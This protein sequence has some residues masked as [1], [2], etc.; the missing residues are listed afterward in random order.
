MTN[1][2][3]TRELG[4]KWA[5]SGTVARARN[6][7]AEPTPVISDA[8][9]QSR[10]ESEVGKNTLRAAFSMDLDEPGLDQKAMARGRHLLKSRHGGSH[11]MRSTG[12][13]ARTK[14]P[15]V[16]NL[17][18]H[19]TEVDGRV[20]ADLPWESCRMDNTSYFGHGSTLFKFYGGTR[21]IVTVPA[22]SK[23][24]QATNTYLV[25]DMR[26]PTK[27]H[28]RERNGAMSQYRRDRLVRYYEHGGLARFTD[29]K[30]DRLQEIK[31]VVR[32]KQAG[33]LHVV[34]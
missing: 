32:A 13:Y 3:E 26:G 14:R 19:T 34:M 10:F 23:P 24:Q 29:K 11:T 18:Y 6:R 31:Q 30:A 8:P 16:T 1:E 5:V 22:E 28:M 27:T 20:L 4:G 9:S 12:R 25:E 33:Q 15:K 7:K 2:R 21:Y 17:G